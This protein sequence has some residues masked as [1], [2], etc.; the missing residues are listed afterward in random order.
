M[1][2]Y[3]KVRNALTGVKGEGASESGSKRVDEDL[4]PVELHPYTGC[5]LPSSPDKMGRNRTYQ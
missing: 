2:D 4:P 3:A 5:A 1:R